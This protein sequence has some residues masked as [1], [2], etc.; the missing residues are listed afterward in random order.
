[1][2][3]IFSSRNN[4]SSRRQRKLEIQLPAPRKKLSRLKNTRTKSRILKALSKNRC[5]PIIEMRASRSKRNMNTD[6]LSTIEIK[7]VV[8]KPWSVE[9]RD[10]VTVFSTT[11]KSME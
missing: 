10:S 3:A 2:R 5:G 11:K 9:R 1:M 7:S 8:I 6:T 4:R